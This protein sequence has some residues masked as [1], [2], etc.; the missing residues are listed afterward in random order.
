MNTISISELKINPSAAIIRAQDYP[1]A[2][3]NR[4]KITGYLLGEKL[5]EAIVRKL[6]DQIDTEAVRNADMTEG[7]SIEVVMKDLGI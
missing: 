4:D 1:V 3:E 6:E 5:F 7:E 2:V